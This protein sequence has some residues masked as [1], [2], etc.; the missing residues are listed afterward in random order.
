[1]FSWVKKE[2]EV[3]KQDINTY[4]ERQY[5]KIDQNM[6]M[7]IQATFREYLKYILSYENNEEIIFKALEKYKS[8][9]L[10]IKNGN[11]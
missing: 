6:N 9:N 11:Q 4:R 1:M 8:D 7:I 2:E 10:D 5:K 3:I